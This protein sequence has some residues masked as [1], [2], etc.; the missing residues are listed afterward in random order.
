M[1]WQRSPADTSAKFTHTPHTSRTHLPEYDS[2]PVMTDRSTSR[3]IFD[4]SSRTSRG[5][6]DSNVKISRSSRKSFDSPSRESRGSF[7]SCTEKSDERVGKQREVINRRA[8]VRSKRLHSIR[9]GEPPGAMLIAALQ[10]ARVTEES[11]LL[12]MAF[13]ILECDLAAIEPS[14]GE[15]LLHLAAKRADKQMCELFLSKNIDVGLR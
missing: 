12:S 6:F 14:T 15:T 3:E 1:C 9:D 5:S 2:C 10:K 13:S 11:K 7:D 8:T 4:S